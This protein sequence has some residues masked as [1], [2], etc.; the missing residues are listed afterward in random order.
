MDCNGPFQIPAESV[1]EMCMDFGSLHEV[2]A[3]SAPVENSLPMTT[4]RGGKRVRFQYSP[5]PELESAGKQSDLQDLPGR[6]PQRVQ[7]VFP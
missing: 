2:L 5:T 6:N 1:A 3:H 4:S 7:S